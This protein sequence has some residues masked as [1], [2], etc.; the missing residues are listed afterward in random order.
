MCQQNHFQTNAKIIYPKYFTQYNCY[1]PALGECHF[2]FYHQ[3]YSH[4]CQGD[5]LEC[6]RHTTW[7]SYQKY[8]P[9]KEQNQWHKSCIV[10]NS[11]VSCTIPLYCV[12]IIPLNR[13]YG[14][15]Q[16]E[17]SHAWTFFTVCFVEWVQKKSNHW[18][19][20]HQPV[21]GV[22]VF[23]VN[24]WVYMVI[25]EQPQTS[26][27]VSAWGRGALF[28]P[29]RLCKIKNHSL[30]SHNFPLKHN[31]LPVHLLLRCRGNA[32]VIVGLAQT[33]FLMN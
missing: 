22:T 17:R 14:V 23:F 1:F 5:L 16:V 18:Y 10:H 3:N 4:H 32:G 11:L 2:C 26:T 31:F 6:H 12:F 20:W 21:W 28:P 24:L 19:S 8:S 25:P 7:N 27:A 33:M 29:H 30:R 13:I 15:G 9:L